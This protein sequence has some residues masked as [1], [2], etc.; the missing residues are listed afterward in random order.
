MDDDLRIAV[1]AKHMI[2]RFQLDA[3]V[4]EVVN[5]AVVSRPDRSIFVADGLMPGGDI[6]DRQAASR[7]SNLWAMKATAGTIFAAGR[8]IIEVEAFAVRPSML[9]HIGHAFEQP[10]INRLAIEVNYS[11]DSAHK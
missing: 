7:Q 9:D 8:R 2:E 4:V 11:A 1:R 10:A 6:N 3:Q 5:L